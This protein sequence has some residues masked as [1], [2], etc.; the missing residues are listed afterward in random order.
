[1]LQREICFICLHPSCSP[2]HLCH[3]VWPQSER[4]LFS[5]LAT[6]HGTLIDAPFSLEWRRHFNLYMYGTKY[7]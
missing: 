7:I 2:A 4:V 3:W 6:Q 5:S 1:M